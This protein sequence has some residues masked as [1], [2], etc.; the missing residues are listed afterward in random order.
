MTLVIKSFLLS[1]IA[2]DPASTIGRQLRCQLPWQLDQVLA[3]SKT[4]L[5]FLRFREVMFVCW[6]TGIHPLIC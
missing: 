4:S 2:N 6:T 3:D 1:V 5:L